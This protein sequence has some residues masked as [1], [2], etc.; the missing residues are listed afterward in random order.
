MNLLEAFASGIQALVAH[1]MRTFLTMLGVMIGVAAVISMISIGDGAKGIIMQDSEKLGGATMIRFFRSRSILKAGRWV[2]NTSREQFTYEDALAIEE[3]CPSVKLA[4]ASIPQ[5][6]GVRITTGAGSSAREMRAGYQ[7]VTPS[8]QEGMSWDA[9]SGR[10]LSDTDVELARS[11]CVIGQEVVT[12]LFDG[13]V[14]LDAEIKV[15]NDRFTVVGVMKPR[16]RSLRYG[17][18]LDDSVFIP[19]TTVQQR[20]TGDDYVRMLSVQAKN[21]ES[22]PKAIEEA[23]E[24]LKKR[25]R[26][27]EFFT[28]R[29]VASGLD[30]VLRVNKII[31]ILLS[32]VAG[33]SLLIGGIGIMNI[34]LVSVTERTREIGLRKALGAKRRD[35]L[36][37]FLLEAVLLCAAGGV[38]GL[39]LGAVFGGGV[40]WIITT[41]VIKTISWPSALPFFWAIVSLVFSALIGVAFGLYPAIRAAR[42]T[43][44]EALRTE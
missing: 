6:W 24:V 42:L 18:N 15:N 25:H 20:F 39:L 3:E 14:P 2:R 32:G 7:G 43:P 10:F 4:M 30:F 13:E 40:A 27:E 36:F 16:G 31:K 35:V 5:F 29:D 38:I 1:K 26:N 19:V 21:I 22:V 41:F 9:E 8:Y 34:M 11:V 12:E 37:Q 44:V 28:T 17:W 33:F 23:T